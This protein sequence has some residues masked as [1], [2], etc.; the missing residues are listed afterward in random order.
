MQEMRWAAMCIALRGLAH[1]VAYIKAHR[2][3]QRQSFRRPLHFVRVA[4][5]RALAH[6]PQLSMEIMEC[7]V[8]PCAASLMWWTQTID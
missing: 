4:N 6:S 7:C 3:G 1:C 8:G 2:L 5:F